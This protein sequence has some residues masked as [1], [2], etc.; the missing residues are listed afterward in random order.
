MG[1]AF[2]VATKAPTTMRSVER[3]TVSIKRTQIQF[4]LQVV[5]AQDPKQCRCI[6]RLY[7]KNRCAK[8]YLH[9]DCHLPVLSCTH[10][11]IGRTKVNSILTFERCFSLKGAQLNFVSIHNNFVTALAPASGGALTAHCWNIIELNASFK[12]FPRDRTN[13]NMVCRLP[14]EQ[15]F[16]HLFFLE[17]YNNRMSY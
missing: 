10:T 4:S 14:I 17:N 9:F 13:N 8:E 5:C 3:K 16:F 15:F 11:H 2:E 7:N 12:S 1:F 6:W